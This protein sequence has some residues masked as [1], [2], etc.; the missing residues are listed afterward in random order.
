LAEFQV[1]E[2]VPLQVLRVLRVLPLVRLLEL[3]LLL[4]RLPLYSPIC[5][6]FVR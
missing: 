3:Q 6:L 1:L 2:L 4:I 5:R